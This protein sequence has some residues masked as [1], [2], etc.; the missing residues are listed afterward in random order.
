MNGEGESTESNRGI[1]GVELRACQ[2]V[3][4]VTVTFTT[5]YPSFPGCPVSFITRALASNMARI[6]P[7]RP[8]SN[9]AACRR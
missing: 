3:D 4:L 6:G 2:G 5:A 8:L 7:N 1:L 9:W